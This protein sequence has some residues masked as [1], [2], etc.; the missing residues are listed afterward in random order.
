MEKIIDGVNVARCKYYKGNCME[1]KHYCQIGCKECTD[2]ET[3]LCH[4]KQVEKFRV[5][6]RQIKA[7]NGKLQQK[8]KKIKELCR[9]EPFCFCSCG[10]DILQIIEEK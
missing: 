6:I 10:D 5:I 9:Q 7:E 3:K 8:L 4:Y 2:I 1:Y